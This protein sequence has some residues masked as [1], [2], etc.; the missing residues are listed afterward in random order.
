MKPIYQTILSLDR[1]RSV[2]GDCFQVSVLELPL[3]KV[4]HFSTD[5]A[6]PV[7]ALSDWLRPR[8]L[9]LTV[10]VLTNSAG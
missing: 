9:E 6:D 3:N 4:P 5:N 1:E 2:F 10:E 7:Q 8:G